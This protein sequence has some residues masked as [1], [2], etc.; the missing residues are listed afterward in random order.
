MPPKKTMSPYNKFVKS[1]FK[2]MKGGTPQAKMKAVAALY[3]K[4]K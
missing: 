1:H 4:H 3:R 2:S